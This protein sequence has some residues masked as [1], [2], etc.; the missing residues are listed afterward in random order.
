MGIVNLLILVVQVPHELDRTGHTQ[1]YELERSY[2]LVLVINSL[3]YFRED[4]MVLDHLIELK[5][6]FVDELPE[7]ITDQSRA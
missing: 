6:V 4:L 7:T 1:H 3:A 2:Q 5:M